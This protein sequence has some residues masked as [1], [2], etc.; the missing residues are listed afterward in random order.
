MLH[1]LAVIVA[2]Y[3]RTAILSLR[4]IERAMSAATPAP[5]NASSDSASP[6]NQQNNEPALQ[7]GAANID[8]MVMAYLQQRGF[9]GAERALRESLGLPSPPAED[10]DS[11][12]APS[13]EVPRTSVSD[14]ELRKHLVPF[15]EMN[16]HPGENVLTDAN[17]TQ[18]GLVTGGVTTPSVATLL[19]EIKPGGADEILSLDPTDKYEGFRD[20]ESWVEGSLD[21]YQVRVTS[22]LT[23]FIPNAYS[24]P[25]SQSSDQSCFLSFVTSI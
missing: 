7:D 21:M 18:K 12:P 1:Y 8:Q 17:V 9:S 11:S 4:R 20:L 19:Q 10:K 14:A 2:H 15:W 25:H 3:C 5:S 24:R 6:S 16:D 22:H 13:E 23:I